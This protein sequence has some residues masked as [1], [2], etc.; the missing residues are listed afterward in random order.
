MSN[1]WGTAPKTLAILKEVNGRDIH[2]KYL[3]MLWKAGKLDR[4]AIDG[5]TYEYNLEQA[6]L[7]HILEKKGSG[8]RKKDEK[9]QSPEKQR[10]S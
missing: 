1:E 6:R 2:P 3:H 8:R 10:P 5:R 7:L 4:R 9:L